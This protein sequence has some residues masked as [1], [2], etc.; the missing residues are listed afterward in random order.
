MWAQARCTTSRQWLLLQHELR[1]KDFGIQQLERQLGFERKLDAW[2]MSELTRREMCEDRMS[3]IVARHCEQENRL[4][5]EEL[6]AD[7]LLGEDRRVEENLWS[8]GVSWW[9]CEAGSTQEMAR[10]IEQQSFEDQARLDPRDRAEYR[11]EVSGIACK[12]VNSFRAR[13]FSAEMLQSERVQ[14]L[15]ERNDMARGKRLRHVMSA[16]HR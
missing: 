4:W 6:A 9:L 3:D 12:L 14:R 16:E 13:R 5:L 15:R 11:S 2:F 7:A 8:Q 1:V 10:G